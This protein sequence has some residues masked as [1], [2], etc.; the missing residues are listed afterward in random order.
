MLA[1]GRDHRVPLDDA[2]LEPGDDGVVH[3]RGLL[4]R[5]LPRWGSS[6]VAMHDDDRTEDEGKLLNPIEDHL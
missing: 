5:Q 2:L 4:T 1:S 6:E 3:A